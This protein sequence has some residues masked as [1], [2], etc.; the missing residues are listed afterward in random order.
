MICCENI[1]DVTPLSTQSFVILKRKLR[2][3]WFG[4]CLKSQFFL[5]IVFSLFLLLFMSF[6]VLF[7]T[8]YKFHYTISIVFEL[9]IEGSFYVFFSKKEVGPGAS[10]NGLQST[11]LLLPGCA[12]TLSPSPSEDI[13]KWAY[14]LF[15]P[16]KELFSSFCCKRNFSPVSAAG[17]TFLLGSKT[18][19][20]AIKLPA[21]Q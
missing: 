2:I 11:I 19:C 14:P 21:V 12:Q 20:Y 8:I 7:G 3:A 9:Y 5:F 13:A 17:L 6:I 15:L 18:F 1:V 10:Q 4:S 16:Q